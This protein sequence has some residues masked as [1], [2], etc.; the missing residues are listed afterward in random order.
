MPHEIVDRVVHRKEYRSAQDP[1]GKLEFDGLFI[2]P[3]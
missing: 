1:I 2:M 3:Q